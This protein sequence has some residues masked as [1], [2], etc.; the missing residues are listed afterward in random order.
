M[1][2][3]PTSGLPSHVGHQAGLR[4]LVRI[5]LLAWVGLHL[6]KVGGPRSGSAPDLED[7]G[8]GSRR[9]EMILQSRGDRTKSAESELPI[10]HRRATSLCKIWDVDL[11]R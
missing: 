10:L 8:R 2:W 9:S 7:F 11:A 4:I 1:L 5:E 3:A 6:R